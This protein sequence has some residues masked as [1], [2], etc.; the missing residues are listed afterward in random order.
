MKE[1]II[2]IL[3]IVLVI[4]LFVLNDLKKELQDEYKHNKILR[5]IIKNVL[6]KEG[7]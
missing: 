7:E 2:L 6:M 4:Q 1:F 5:E 3:T